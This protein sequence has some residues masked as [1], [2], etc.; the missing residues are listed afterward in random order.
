[1]RRGGSWLCCGVFCEVWGFLLGGVEWLG[2]VPPG[3]GVGCRNVGVWGCVCVWE[4]GFVGGWGV[5]RG[6]FGLGV[7][8]VLVLGVRGG[9]V[10]GVPSDSIRLL[11]FTE[12]GTQ[13]GLPAR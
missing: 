12:N 8:G 6:G 2:G 9:C 3:G 5:G 1:V 4:L 10:G 13:R 11:H 7:M